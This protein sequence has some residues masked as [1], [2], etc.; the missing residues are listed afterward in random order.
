MASAADKLV[1]LFE[2]RRLAETDPSVNPQSKDIIGALTPLL[3]VIRDLSMRSELRTMVGDRKCSSV[4]DHQYPEAVHRLLQCGHA[5]IL[6][7]SDWTAF[8]R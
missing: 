3:T 5:D 1:L 6:E 2:P 7:P 4:A 8:T